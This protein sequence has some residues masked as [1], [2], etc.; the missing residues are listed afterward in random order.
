MQTNTE[1]NTVTDVNENS[2]LLDRLNLQ[3]EPKGIT[4]PV[5]TASN[6]NV[7]QNNTTGTFWNSDDDLETPPAPPETITTELP[8]T[9]KKLTD[10]VFKNG[11]SIVTGGLEFVSSGIIMVILKR[12]FKKQFTTQEY[13]TYLLALDKKDIDLT[14]DER[15]I[16]NRISV[17]VKKYEE[18]KLKV[19]FT[20]D[21]EQD[22]EKAWYQYLKMKNIE[23]PPGMLVALATTSIIGKRVL[24]VALDD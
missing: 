3:T 5:V 9:D 17:A 16:K 19:P 12:R 18:L 20:D 24:D 10:A 1:N 7:N 14:D 21:E 22:L 6:T 13:D 8:T 4:A 11:A 2:S 23:V 15:K